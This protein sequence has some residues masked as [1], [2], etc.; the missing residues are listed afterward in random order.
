MSQI[1]LGIV[2]Q[3]EAVTF[4]N[5]EVIVF[6]NEVLKILIHKAGQEHKAISKVAIEPVLEL[7]YD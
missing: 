1:D 4:Y 6:A 7:N 5:N 2:T 3:K